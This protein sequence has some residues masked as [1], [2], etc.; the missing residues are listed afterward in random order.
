MRAINYLRSADSRPQDGTEDIPPISRYE[1]HFVWLGGTSDHGRLTTGGRRPRMS[2][3][4]E[5]DPH[6]R[7][8]RAHDR[9]PSGLPSGGPTPAP[10]SNR[11]RSPARTSMPMSAWD[12]VIDRHLSGNDGR[13]R[14]RGLTEMRTGAEDDGRGGHG[15]VRG[16]RPRSHNPSVRLTRSQAEQGTTCGPDFN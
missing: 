14:T 7:R 10:R 15:V 13:T 5:P 2:S 11:R 4:H 16:R 8:H 9:W 12:G 1:F 3:I 6:G